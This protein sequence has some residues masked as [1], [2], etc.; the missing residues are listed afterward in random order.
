[1]ITETRKMIWN[2]SVIRSWKIRSEYK[3]FVGNTE[4]RDNLRDL[5]KME[6]YYCGFQRN[7]TC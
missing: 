4:R 3:I 2:G 5:K 7:G 6:E 1:L